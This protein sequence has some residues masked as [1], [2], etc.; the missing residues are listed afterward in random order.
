EPEAPAQ[1]ERPKVERKWVGE[2]SNAEAIRWLTP[3]AD[4]LDHLADRADAQDKALFKMQEKLDTMELDLGGFLDELGN[5]CATTKALE[6][7]LKALEA[8]AKP[9]PVSEPC[10]LVD[11]AG[12]NQD[13]CNYLEEKA[14]LMLPLIHAGRIMEIVKSHL[15]KEGGE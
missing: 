4:E 14:G 1:G 10:G 6:K 2:R 8:Q 5:N 11:W 7:R 3:L 12:V 15:S 13:L 9:E